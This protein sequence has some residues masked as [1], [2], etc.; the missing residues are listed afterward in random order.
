MG[1]LEFVQSVFRA[2]N[3][4]AGHHNHE[5]QVRLLCVVLFDAFDRQFAYYVRSV[6]LILMSVGPLGFLYVPKVM[7]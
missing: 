1:W 4:C 7:L 5:Q 3:R 6:A 2:V